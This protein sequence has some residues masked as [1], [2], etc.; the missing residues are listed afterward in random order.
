VRR[1]DGI[2]AGIF[3]GAWLLAAAFLLT[4]APRAGASL[5]TRGFFPAAVAVGWLAGN[6]YVAGSRGRRELRR[7]LLALY[8]GGA[9]GLLWLYWSLVPLDQRLASSISPLLAL[10]IFALFFLVPVSLRGFPR[11]R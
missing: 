11:R 1:L 8:L 7:T 5:P 10:G 3:V 2:A 6:F 4:N 9:P